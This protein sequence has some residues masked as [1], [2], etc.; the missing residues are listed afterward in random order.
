MKQQADWTSFEGIITGL[1]EGSPIAILVTAL[2]AF[3][4]PVLLHFIFYR[5]VASPPLSNFLLLGPSGSGKTALVSLVGSLHSL[6]SP[7]FTLSRPISCGAKTDTLASLQLESKSSRLVK[8][9]KA[10]HTSQASTLA[11]VT[12]PVSITAASNRFRSVND[13]SLKDISKNPIR[14]NVKDTP[15]HGKLR[16]SQ[17]VVQLESMANTKD[18]NLRARAVVFAIDTAALSQDEVLRDTANYLHNVLL[19][20]QKRALSKGK[21]AQGV[22]EE[23]PVLVAANKQD[24]FTALP[25]G[26]VREKLE[27]EIERIRKSRS[28]GLMD[29]SVDSGVGDNEDETLGNDNGQDTFTFKLLEDEVGIKVDVVGGAVKGDEEG[30]VGAGV[31]KWEEW[32]AQYL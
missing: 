24:L 32:I 7:L 5:T 14:Y 12:L 23:V 4:L 26:S 16:D 20:L 18:A 22:A 21:N 28:K 27:A 11:T 13:S 3:G 8:K 25:P 15:G 17:G 9:P 2:I 10:T 6:I 29:A 31:R 30:N 1:L 19:V